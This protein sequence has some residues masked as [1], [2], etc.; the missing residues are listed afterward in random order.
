MHSAVFAGLVQHR[1]SGCFVADPYGSL[2][3]S[4]VGGLL[5]VLTKEPAQWL[6]CA[7]MCSCCHNET[8]EIHIKQWDLF[9]NVWRKRVGISKHVH[10]QSDHFCAHTVLFSFHFFV[11][12]QSLN[13]DFSN[14]G[15]ACICVLSARVEP[16]CHTGHENNN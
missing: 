3:R 1:I 7:W 5:G 15:P 8:Q 4:V 12:G 10:Q 9:S 14:Q 16:W 11:H 13:Y 6:V 2:V